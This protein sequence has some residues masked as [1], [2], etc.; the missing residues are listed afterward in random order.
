[1]VKINFLGSCREVGRSAILIESKSGEKGLLDFGV[2]FDAEERLPLETDLRGLKFAALTHCHVDHSGALPALYRN[3]DPI[4]F[5]KSQ[6][7][8]RERLLHHIL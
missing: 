5:T 7:E 6:T 3:A 4:L 8:D 2:R 1:M